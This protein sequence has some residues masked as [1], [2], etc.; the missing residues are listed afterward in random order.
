LKEAVAAYTDQTKEIVINYSF[1][2]MH[3]KVDFIIADLNPNSFKTIKLLE[4][5]GLSG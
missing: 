5:R 1:E 4:K 2:I 3:F